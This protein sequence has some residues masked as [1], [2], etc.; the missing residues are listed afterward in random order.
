MEVTQGA[1]DENQLSLMVASGDMPDIICS[2]TGISILQILRF[3]IHWMNFMKCT[4][5]FHSEVD[6]GISSCSEQG[7]L[8]VIIIRLDG[9]FS[10]LRLYKEYDKILTEGPG[11]MYR[12][13]IWMNWG[14]NLIPWMSFGYGV[15]KKLSQAYPD[16]MVC[17]FNCIHKF[18]WLMQQI[19]T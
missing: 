10:R 11:F 17:S 18:N 13:N 2:L 4:L 3:V 16:Y 9:L 19:R 8:M 12:K 7:F 15:W 5:M 14:L 6:P 1:A